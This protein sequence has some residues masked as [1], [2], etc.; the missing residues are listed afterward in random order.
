MSTSVKAVNLSKKYSLQDNYQGNKMLKE[1]LTDFIRKPFRQFKKSKEK[2]PLKGHD[3]WA[4]K[5]VSFNIQQGEIVG[6]IGRNGAGKTTLLKILSKITDP[7]SGHAEV[8]GR[9]SSLLEIGTGFHQELTGRE[10]VYLNGAILGI[11][12]SEIT[13]KFDEIVDFAEIGDFLDTPVKHYSSGMFVRLAFAVAAHLDSEILLIDEVLAVGDIQF[14][15]KCLQKTKDIMKKGRTVLFVSHNINAIVSLCNNGIFLEKGSIIPTKNL[16]E[17][18]KLYARDYS[19]R[20][21]TAWTGTV[22]DEIVK[23]YHAKVTSDKRGRL[24]YRG[25]KFLLELEYEIFRQ[26]SKIV[27][28]IDIYNRNGI[29]LCATRLTDMLKGEQL[30]KVQKNGKHFASVEVDTSILS[31]GEYI[32]KFNFG[33]HNIRRIIEDEPILSFGVINPQKNIHHDSSL[34]TN[35]VFPD[36]QWKERIT[37]NQ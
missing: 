2:N 34:Y 36:W 16:E 23:L 10:N 6:I 30:E 27:I 5:N 15:K 25:E 1:A 14:Q 26:D 24:F 29:F 9:V 18:I 32:I 28:G 13:H 17:C 20:S 19:E 22:G 35:I 8:Q 7:T 4:L 21:E 33:L 11:K 3:I 37:E 31:E 12:K